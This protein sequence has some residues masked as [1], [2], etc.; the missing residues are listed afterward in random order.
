MRRF[1]SSLGAGKA[2]I[3]G[4]GELLQK[5]STRVANNEKRKERAKNGGFLWITI[6]SSLFERRN[7]NSIV[8]AIFGKETKLFTVLGVSAA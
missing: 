3:V 2:G 6:S 4:H 5:A 7:D 1:E 8:E